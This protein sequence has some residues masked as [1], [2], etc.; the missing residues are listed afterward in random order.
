MISIKNQHMI[1]INVVDLAEKMLDTNLR[2][3]ERLNYQL[4][5]EAIRDYCTLTINKSLSQKPVNKQNT[6]VYR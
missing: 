1:P 6:R 2:E 3:N 4:R 5:I